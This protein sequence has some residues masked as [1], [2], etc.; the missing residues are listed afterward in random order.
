MKDFIE[1]QLKILEKVKKSYCENIDLKSQ[2]YD[3]IGK[4]VCIRVQ[5]ATIW[6]YY[7]LS[8]YY[9]SSNAKPN[10]AVKAFKSREFELI[11]IYCNKELYTYLVKKTKELE[12]YDLLQCLRT[13]ALGKHHSHFHKWFDTSKGAT[14][15]WYVKISNSYHHD[16]IAPPYL[17]GETIRH[18]STVYHDAEAMNKYTQW[19][20][21]DTTAFL[22][23]GL[24]REARQ[25]YT[26][27]MNI[28]TKL[29]EFDEL[30]S[31]EDWDK[32]YKLFWSGTTI[33]NLD[34][35][36]NKLIRNCEF[37]LALYFRTSAYYRLWVNCPEDVLKSCDE[38]FTER[39][40]I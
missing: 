33:V 15:M 8:E 38:P 2:V 1:S 14:H 35:S 6:K 28:P 34:E 32:F 7:Q 30:E 5:L 19:C 12:C 16:I 24:F 25:S 10:T 13:S 23:Q 4:F 39:Q 17:D 31:E 21:L 37:D 26:R 29:R 40:V 27:V 18:P 20:S 9:F 3:A 22:I 11:H 36:Y